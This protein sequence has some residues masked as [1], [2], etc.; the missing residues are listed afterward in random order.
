VGDAGALRRFVG[1]QEARGPG[2]VWS[3]PWR[4]QRIG[5]CQRWEAAQLAGIAASHEQRIG[6]RGCAN[7]T[8]EMFW[9]FS[10]YGKRVLGSAGWLDG[11]MGWDGMGDQ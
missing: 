4:G 5:W 6:P 8:G 1:N 2:G 10:A 9:G 11:W 7:W 3:Q